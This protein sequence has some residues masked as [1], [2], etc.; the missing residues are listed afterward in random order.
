MPARVT[1]W[2]GRLIGLAS[3]GAFASFSTIFLINIIQILVRPFGGGFI[4]VHDLSALLFAWTVM[5]GAAAAYGKFDH[6]VA[7]FLVDKFPPT[8][9]QVL[10]YFVRVIEITVAFILLM[11]SL[12][13]VE[14]RMN[15]S[16]IQLGIPTGWAYLSV[17][18]LGAFMLVFG[19]TAAPRAATA[20]EQL[21]EELDS[22]ATK[23]N[24]GEVRL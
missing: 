2:R 10:A 12:Q 19:L 13:I 3:W 8:G 16:Y 7:S 22:L 4:W 21:D 17:T 5:L 18:A 11:A 1:L 24:E 15:I 14:T 9:R 23:P 6:I 20:G